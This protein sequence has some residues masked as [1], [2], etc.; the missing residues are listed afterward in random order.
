M[1]EA[2]DPPPIEVTISA[3]PEEI[4]RALREP[5]L[6]RRWHGWHY[7][8]LDEE[9][10]QIFV[11]G[12]TEDPEARTFVAGGNDRFSLHPAGSGGTTVRITRGPRGTDPDWDAY[13]DDITEGWRT[14]LLQLRFGLERHAMAERR[15][16]FLNDALAAPGRKLVDHLGLAEAGEQPVGTRYRVAL[17]TGDEFQGELYFSSE[18][19]RIFTVDGLGDGL[20]VVAHQPIAEH[21]PMPAG[22]I[23]L[24]AYDVAENRFAELEQRWR[25]WWETTRHQPTS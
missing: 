4:W 15:T 16:L 24:T 7:D 8:G 25:S 5:E 10:R 20:L 18:H 23:V 22:L 2:A 11:D 13:Y 1:T 9:V 19:Q 17:P 21:R 6:I 3:P 14:F 12:V